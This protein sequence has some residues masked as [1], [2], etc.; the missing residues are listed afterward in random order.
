MTDAHDCSHP[1]EPHAS[2]SAMHLEFRCEMS[3][4]KGTLELAASLGLQVVKVE[5]QFFVFG[6]PRRVRH[7][8]DTRTDYGEATREPPTASWLRI[9]HS[10]PIRPRFCFGS[11]QSAPLHGDRQRVGVG[12]CTSG[13]IKAPAEM[14]EGNVGMRSGSEQ[15]DLV[16]RTLEA[17]TR[18]FSQR[19]TGIDYARPDRFR[20]CLGKKGHISL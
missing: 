13:H 6:R 5:L 14:L 15:N 17:G 18:G 1:P 4:G 3:P 16:H 9:S 2:S 20:R 11:S 19:P 10:L 8:A 12:V 7:V